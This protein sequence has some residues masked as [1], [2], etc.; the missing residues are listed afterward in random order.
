M[1]KNLPANAGD[2][3]LIPGPGRSHMPTCH[4]YSACAPETGS[5]NFC[6]HMP[7][8]LKPAL[9]L[10]SATREA[11]ALR[12]PHTMRSSPCTADRESPCN[13]ED[14]TP[15]INKIT[16]K[17]SFFKISNYFHYFCL[18]PQLSPCMHTKSLQLCPTLCYPMESARLLCLCDPK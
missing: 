17:N 12:N 13:N 7:Q 2:T 1:A 14:S 11:T 3:D 8:L 10:C 15:K 9:S 6:D 5:C 18:F 16:L 4:N